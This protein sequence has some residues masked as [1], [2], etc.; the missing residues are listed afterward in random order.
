MPIVKDNFT[1]TDGE[2]VTIYVEVDSIQQQNRYYGD[3]RGQGD[4]VIDTAKDIFGSGMQ[5]IRIC[6][7]QVV[8]T[9]QKVDQAVRPSE[10]QVQLAIKLDSTVGAVLAKASAE[11]QLQVTLKWV[12]KEQ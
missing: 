1:S 9:I 5:L 6:A 11:A 10:F 7:E 4:Q 2:E 3:L 12:K 8:S